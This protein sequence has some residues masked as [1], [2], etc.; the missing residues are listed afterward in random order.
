MS[1][2]IVE[3]RAQDLFRSGKEPS[4][5]LDATLALFMRETRHNRELMRIFL[6]VL[7]QSAYAD[8]TLHREE[9]RILL[10]IS[11]RLGFSRGEPAALAVPYARK[12][13][14]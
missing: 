3:R 13:E 8:G 4:F 9:Q 14:A 12:A 7:L 10:H 1:G 5:S 6:E 11:D 2:V